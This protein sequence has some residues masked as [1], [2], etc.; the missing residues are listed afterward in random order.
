MDARWL[1]ILGLV[2]LTAAVLVEL[3]AQMT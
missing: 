3:A 1:C 2:M